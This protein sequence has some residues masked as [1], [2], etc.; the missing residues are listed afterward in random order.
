MN[1]ERLALKQHVHND[2]DIQE[3]GH[4]SRYRWPYLCIL[5]SSIQR[6]TSSS[7][8]GGC[9]VRKSP[10]ARQGISRRYSQRLISQCPNWIIQQRSPILQRPSCYRFEDISIFE[11]GNRNCTSPN[12]IIPRLPRVFFFSACIPPRGDA[13]NFTADFRLMVAT[14]RGSGWFRETE[15]W[16]AERFRAYWW[17]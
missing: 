11:L 7:D 5:Y 8:G 6:L 17:H 1:E 14:I 3:Y 4:W 13:G 12:D 15:E 10:R 2:I 9:A 16:I